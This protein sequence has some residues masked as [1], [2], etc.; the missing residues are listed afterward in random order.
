MPRVVELRCRLLGCPARGFQRG[1]LFG[2]LLGP[3]L[4]RLGL[5]GFDQLK[6][7]SR[8]VVALGIIPGRIACCRI[9]FVRVRA[10]FNPE[11]LADF[12][13]DPKIFGI[14]LND[15]ERQAKRIEENSKPTDEGVTEEKKDN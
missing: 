15:N 6:R 14:S 13:N 2:M 7:L 5:L 10:T 4:A 8:A 9:R 11:K 1:C 3:G 12:I